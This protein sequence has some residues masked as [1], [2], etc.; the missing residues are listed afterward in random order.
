MGPD[1]ATG[2]AIASAVMRLLDEPSFRV[3]AQ[4]VSAEITGMPSPA[5]VVDVLSE[6]AR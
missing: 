5:D 2:E 1:V 3:A 4:E 6:L